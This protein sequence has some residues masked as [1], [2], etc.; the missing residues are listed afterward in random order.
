[1]LRALG[2]VPMKTV[3]KLSSGGAQEVGAMISQGHVH[4][5]FTFDDPFCSCKQ[6]CQ[7]S[8]LAESCNMC[9]ATNFRSSA[10]MLKAMY[11]EM[12]T[13]QGVGMTKVEVLTR[14]PSADHMHAPEPLLPLDTVANRPETGPHCAAACRRAP[15]SHCALPGSPQQTCC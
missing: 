14:L 6:V 1:M 10:A 13:G 9:H 11:D 2:L 3:S 4:A 8:L 7:L 5:V 15:P 12:R